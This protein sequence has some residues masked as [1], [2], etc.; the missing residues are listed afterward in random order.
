MFQDLQW[1]T[2]ME[3]LLLG[4][5]LFPVREDCV[6]TTD[7]SSLGWGGVLE[8]LPGIN[9]LTVQGKWTLSQQEWHI[10]Y[11]ELMAVF[12][13]LQHFQDQLKDKQ[14]LIRL[15]NM[16]TCA[17]INKGGGRGLR[18][19]AIWPFSCGIGARIT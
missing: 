1:W 7:A 12:L 2:Q 13:T 4:L 3:N 6:V 15:D 19:F 11:Q 16:T 8:G 14:V 9:I 10:N 18:T 5:P 17:S